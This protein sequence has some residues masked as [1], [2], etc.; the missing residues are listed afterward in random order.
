MSMANW[1][2]GVLSSTG[3]FGLVFLMFTEN[4]FPPIPSELIVP[5]AGYLTRMGKLTLAGVIVAG[6]LGSLLGAIFLYYFG[7]KLGY[8]RTCE[9]AQ[10]R[11]RWLT[12][13]EKDVAR[14]KKWFDRHG[15]MAVFIC[16]LVPG[17][18]SLISIPAG[19]SR[20][21]LPAFIA[22]TTAGSALWTAILTALGWALAQNYKVVDRYLDPVSAV[23]VGGIVVL[24]IV[25]VVRHN[26]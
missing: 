1:V 8:R 21:P 11:G 4:V 5:L 2:T 17:I 23:L 16:R 25:R 24:Y 19:I 22:Y 18:R 20:M 26:K 13:S 15:G 14:A 10:R 6:T 3:Y 12:V 7:R 9:F